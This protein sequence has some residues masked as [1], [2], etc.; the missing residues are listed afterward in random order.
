MTEKFECEKCGQEF[1]SK[2]KLNSH[3]KIKT[4]LKLLKEALNLK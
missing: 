2:E 4:Q 3:E 1:S